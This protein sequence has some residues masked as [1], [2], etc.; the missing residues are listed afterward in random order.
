MV[1]DWM[2]L[3]QRN[4]ATFLQTEIDSGRTKKF[5]ILYKKMQ[6]EL[7]EEVC[8][9]CDGSGKRSDLSCNICDGKGKRKPWIV[10]EYPFDTDNVQEFV[11]F[12]KGCGGFAIC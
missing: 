4:L 5:E 11:T 7:P 12:L 3:M 2:L 1:M 8:F 6:D 10:A 9:V